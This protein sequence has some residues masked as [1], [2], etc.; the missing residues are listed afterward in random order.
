[1]NKCKCGKDGIRCYDPFDEVIYDKKTVITVC[2][3]CYA[4]RTVKMES[5]RFENT[6]LTMNAYIG[7]QQRYNKI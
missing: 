4:K 2:P 7:Q 6:D 1:M 3:A 5:W